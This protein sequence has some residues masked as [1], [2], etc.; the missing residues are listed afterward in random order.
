MACSD[1]C[2][3][4]LARL[5]PFFFLYYPLFEI[6]GRMRAVQE[7]MALPT[8][9]RRCRGMSAVRGVSD[10]PPDANSS[11]LA[12]PATPSTWGY[13]WTGSGHRH[14]LKIFP[15]MPWSPPAEED[16]PSPALATTSRSGQTLVAVQDVY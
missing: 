5:H 15:H 1:L 2:C 14:Q 13:P 3:G 12:T 6:T 11:F 4:E 8:L 16:I 7:R 9:W 10:P